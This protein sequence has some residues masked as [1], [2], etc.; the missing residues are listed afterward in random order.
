MHAID[1]ALRPVL[2]AL[3]VR[4][5]LEPVIASDA[6]IIEIDCGGYQLDAQTRWRI[7]RS[8]RG[9]IERAMPQ[10]S[11]AEANAACEADAVLARI[12]AHHGDARAVI[13]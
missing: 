7:E 6:Q 2:A 12:C 11:A 8:M 10:R 5:V 9:L 4:E 1:H 13:R 3:G